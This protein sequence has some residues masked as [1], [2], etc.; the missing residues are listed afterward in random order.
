MLIAATLMLPLAML[1][2]CMSQRWRDRMPA[3]LVFAPLPAIAAALQE[4]HGSMAQ[5]WSC[6]THCSA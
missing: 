2:A 6:P 4:F 1:A 3:L 5:F